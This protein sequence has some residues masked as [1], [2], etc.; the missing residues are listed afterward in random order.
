MDRIRPGGVFGEG[1]PGLTAGLEDGLGVFKDPI[2]EESVLQ[3]FPDGFLRIE[4]RTVRRKRKKGEVL[5][6]LEGSVPGSSIR[7]SFG[8][9]SRFPR[10]P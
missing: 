9:R 5:R 1:V 10:S 4:L 7:R 3:I 2:R 8:I 6:N